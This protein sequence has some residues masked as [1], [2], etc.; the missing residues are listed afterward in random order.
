MA[1][2]ARFKKEFVTVLVGSS[3]T[4]KEKQSSL[5]EQLL[6]V[7]CCGFFTVANM[8]YAELDHAAVEAIDAITHL[9][10]LKQN[11]KQ[12]TALAA[13]AIQRVYL[14]SS[15]KSGIVKFA[16]Q[17][18]AEQ[19]DAHCLF[20]KGVF[21]KIQSFI[22]FMVPDG[23]EE[24][25]EESDATM[26]NEESLSNLCGLMVDIPDGT[27]F[28]TKVYSSKFGKDTLSKGMPP[29]NAPKSY[30]TLMD[31]I[32]TNLQQVLLGHTSYLQGNADLKNKKHIKNK[33][34][35]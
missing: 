7:I 19:W 32:A 24:S 4:F 14:K 31:A 34:K 18:G 25:T 6:E 13:Q 16:A 15:E 23:E 33:N 28:A 20:V 12:K 17:E 9:Q 29:L 10:G 8:M 22:P 5:I 35:R 21:E 26:A 2:L 30:Q 27:V 11:K 3:K 1:N